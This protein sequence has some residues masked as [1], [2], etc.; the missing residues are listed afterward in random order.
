VR[1]K[2]TYDGDRRE[3]AVNDYMDLYRGL[4]KVRGSGY[5]LQ[6]TRSCAVRAGSCVYRACIVSLPFTV[7]LPNLVSMRASSVNKNTRSP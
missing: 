5:G 3:A 7:N 2:T 6:G 1:E 4:E